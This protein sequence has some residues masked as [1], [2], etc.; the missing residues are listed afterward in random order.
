MKKL[1][2]LTLVFAFML[3]ACGGVKATVGD[4]AYSKETQVIVEKWIA[5]FQKRD[6]NALWSLYSN[7]LTWKDCSAVTCFTLSLVTL[8]DELPPYFADP[9]FQMKI[10]SYIVTEF[11]RFA[12]LQ[13]TF[14]NASDNVPAPTPI[15]LILEIKNGLI[16][17]ET[18]YYF[19][20]S[21]P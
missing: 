6:A 21:M 4:D 17:Y 9:K 8:K 7:D 16:L 13:G 15:Y 18:W 3:S 20:I 12:V 14:L 10:K 11:G 1:F 5:A 19:G 2:L